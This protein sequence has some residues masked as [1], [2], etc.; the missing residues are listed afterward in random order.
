MSRAKKLLLVNGILLV[1]VG[2]AFGYFLNYTSEPG[3]CASC[4]S[5]EPYEASWEGS[6]HEAVGVTCIDCHFDTGALGY[7]E[8]KVYSFMKLTQWVVEKRSRSLRLTRLWLPDHAG[9]VT[10]IPRPLSYHTGFIRK[11][12]I[13]IA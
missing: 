3:F 7:I 8:G 6:T 12:R 2:V 1:I 10:Q 5:I 11:S 4:H 13:L 9:N